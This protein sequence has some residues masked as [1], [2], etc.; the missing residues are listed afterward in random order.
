MDGFVVI[1]LTRMKV[2][3]QHSICM[4]CS[5]GHWP[6]D[7]FH[8]L[9]CQLLA[10]KYDTSN[11]LFSQVSQTSSEKKVA[12]YINRL[13]KC[14]K[15]FVREGSLTSNLQSQSTR[16]GSAVRAASN[17]N[18]SLADVAHRGRWTLDGFAC[19]SSTSAKRMQT[20]KR[21]RRCWAAWTTLITL[22][23]RRLLTCCC[24]VARQNRGTLSQQLRLVRWLLL[25]RRVE[26]ILEYSHG[27]FAD[28][29]G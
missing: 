26:R 22:N 27:L 16:R 1:Y 10:T 7:P 5:A 13:L 14:T 9:A 11:L 20:I 23:D 6:I 28:V 4:F 15:A 29:L 8:S 12:A 2:R 21:L 18:V 19:C 24:S 3:K 25:S 17:A